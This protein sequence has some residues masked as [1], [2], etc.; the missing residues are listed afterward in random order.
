MT[1]VSEED[2]KERRLKDC[3]SLNPRPGGVCDRE[4]LKN[5]FF[6][7]RDLVQVKYEMLRKV[8]EDNMPVS[9]AAAAFGFSR[10]AFYQVQKAF[11][12]R[13]LPGLLPMKRGPRRAHK[14]TEEV[15]DFIQE[16]MDA[17]GINAFKVAPLVEDR[18]GI[19]VHPRSIQRALSRRREEKRKGVKRCDLAGKKR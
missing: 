11:E 12:D 5:E 4:F 3:G 15:L 2:E 9:R 10:T 19:S 1:E 8:Y 13:G 6:D 18:F 14:L 16:R 17:E 7:T